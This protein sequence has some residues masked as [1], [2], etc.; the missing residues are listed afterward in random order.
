MSKIINVNQIDRNQIF[1]V[2]SD[3]ISTTKAIAGIEHVSDLQMDMLIMM[4]DA[5]LES[6]TIKLNETQ[7]FNYNK[8]REQWNTTKSTDLNTATYEID[9][10]FNG[11][12][13]SI[14]LPDSTISKTPKGLKREAR[15]IQ[16]NYKQTLKNQGYKF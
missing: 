13:T 14:T 12:G 6:G 2:F 3:K 16:R 11:D 15:E 9:Y 5:M 1:D 4:F 10:A 7:T 8:M